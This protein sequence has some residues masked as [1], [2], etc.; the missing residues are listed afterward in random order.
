MQSIETKSS[1]NEDSK[2]FK[3]IGENKGLHKWTKSN[4][5]KGRQENMLNQLVIQRKKKERKRD[6]KGGRK[7]ERLCLF[8]Q[9]IK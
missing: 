5:N 4:I 1:N 2:A 9:E 6:W 7:N 8:F 3:D